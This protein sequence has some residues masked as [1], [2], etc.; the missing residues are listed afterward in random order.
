MPFKP[1]RQKIAT[2]KIPS[3]R[4]FQLRNAGEK[5]AGKGEPGGGNEYRLKA[6]GKIRYS[7]NSRENYVMEASELELKGGVSDTGF[8]PENIEKQ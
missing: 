8:Q 5:S 7:V 2:R 4:L 1:S 6:P 3:A